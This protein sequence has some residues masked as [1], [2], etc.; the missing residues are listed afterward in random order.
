MPAVQHLDGGVAV[1]DPWRGGGQ[2]YAVLEL[3][4]HPLRGARQLDL[5]R[6]ALR[7]GVLGIGR[8]GDGAERTAQAVVANDLVHAQNARRHAIAAQRAHMRVAT[9]PIQDR[10]HPRAQ[11][12]PDGHFNFL[13]LWPLKLPQ[14]G[15]TDYGFSDPRLS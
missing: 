4:L 15:R 10:Q 7:I 11:H 14:A 5:L 2:R 3:S 6:C 8:R 13:H 12:V 9:M 1:Q